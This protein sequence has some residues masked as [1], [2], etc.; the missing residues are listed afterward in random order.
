MEIIN[1][2]LQVSKF[3]FREGEVTPRS[4]QKVKDIANTLLSS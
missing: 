4:T 1:L 2:R 3:K